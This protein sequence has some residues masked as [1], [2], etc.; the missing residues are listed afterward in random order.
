MRRNPV[1]TIIFILVGLSSYGADV[2]TV[3]YFRRSNEY[4]KS[5]RLFAFQNQKKMNFSLDQICSR[6]E[7]N[8]RKKNGVVYEIYSEVKIMPGELE[9][10]LETF[11]TCKT[12]IIHF[13][14]P[15]SLVNPSEPE[16][17]YGPGAL[18]GSNSNQLGH[19]F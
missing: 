5:E 6:L 19:Q 13:W 3:R 10:I 15:V 4:G 9:S 1:V 2:I 11:S 14:V 16:G 12:E 17:K 18:F 7:S 8:Y